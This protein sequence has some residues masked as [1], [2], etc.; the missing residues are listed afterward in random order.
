MKK[1]FEYKIFFPNSSPMPSLTFQLSNANGDHAEII[2]AG[3]DTGFDGFLV[4]TDELYSKLNLSVAKIPKEI[5]SHGLTATGE[6]V[7][8]NTS[9]GLISIGDI[10]KDLEI[11]VDSYKNCLFPLVGRQL[12]SIFWTFLQGPENICSIEIKE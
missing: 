2:H 11:E 12:L 4:I 8:F 7:D 3:I 1:E 9:F 6:R 5:A 10:V